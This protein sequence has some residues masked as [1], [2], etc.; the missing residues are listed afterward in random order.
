MEAG[1]ADREKKG[2]GQSRRESKKKRVL[3]DEGFGL[4]GRVKKMEGKQKVEK[5]DIKLRRMNKKRGDQAGEFQ[6]F[7][8]M[9]W[10][11]YVLALIHHLLFFLYLKQFISLQPFAKGYSASLESLPRSA[12]SILS[13]PSFTFRYST[14][15]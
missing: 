4:K 11:K 7:S 6:V 14:V 13:A 9:L 12:R 3:K 2:V 15:Y 10:D 8:V 1:G 5:F